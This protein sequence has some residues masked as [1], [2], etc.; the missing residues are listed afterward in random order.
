MNTTRT[1]ELVV[2][3]L[4]GRLVITF[5]PVTGANELLRITPLADRAGLRIEGELDCSTLPALRAAL[6]TMANGDVGFCVDLS[7][8]AF[9][10][11]GCLRIL[12]SAATSLHESGG[13]KVLTLRSVPPQMRR[14]LELTGW[15][16]TLGLHVQH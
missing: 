15:H 5:L 7:R 1:F 9:I 10:D 2:A 11:T 16:R 6:A 4:I 14:L 12:V 13:D 8:V 3:V